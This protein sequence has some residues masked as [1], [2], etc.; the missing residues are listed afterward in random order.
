M[1]TVEGKMRSAITKYNMISPGDSIAVGLSGGKDSVA[2]LTA[3]AHLR[4][5]LGIDFALSAIT[6]DPQFNNEPADLSPLKAHCEKLG[7]HY[8]IYKSTLYDIIFN[9]RRENNPCSMCARMRRGILCRICNENGINKLA[10]GHHLDD[11]IQT[12]FMNLFDGG[13]ISCFAPMSHMSRSDV[14]LIRPMLFVSEREI[15]HA[16]RCNDLPTVKFAC[17]VD[18]DTERHNVAQT[19]IELEKQYPDL[20]SKVMGAMQRSH[21]NGL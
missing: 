10:L 21:L 14:W 12:F 4:D 18:G 1:Q 20:K 6:V 7:V 11:E 2:L 19:I 13:S 17:P 5:Y 3:L 9:Q 16:V 8:I 15:A